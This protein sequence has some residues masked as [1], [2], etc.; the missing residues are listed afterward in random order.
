MAMFR[1]TYQ[2]PCT[3][4]HEKLTGL[5]LVKKILQVLFSQINP[6]LAPLPFISNQF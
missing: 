2:M 1:K 6:V 3:K 4:V 5:Q